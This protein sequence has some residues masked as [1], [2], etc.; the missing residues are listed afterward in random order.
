M[1]VEVV[2]LGQQEEQ[3]IVLLMKEVEVVVVEG[4]TIFPILVPL[5]R[6]TRPSSV[7]G[8]TLQCQH[9]PHNLQGVRVLINIFLQFSLP[10]SYPLNKDTLTPEARALS[11]SP[12]TP[13]PPKQ[14]QT[15]PC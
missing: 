5:H 3:Q 12:I 2:T 7:Q 6:A 14:K 4:P 13:P 15:P 1:E 10:P 9:V 8:C 11:L